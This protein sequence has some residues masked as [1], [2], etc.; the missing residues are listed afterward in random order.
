MDV[1]YKCMT[2]ACPRCKDACSTVFI[3]KVKTHI[4][5][6]S[7]HHLLIFR[8]INQKATNSFSND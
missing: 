3:P 8:Q 1:K 4:Y 6:T 5:H 7:T 2:D